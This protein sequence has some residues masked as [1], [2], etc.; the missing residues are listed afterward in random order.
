MLTNQWQSEPGHTNSALTAD[1]GGTALDAD[2]PAT[3]EFTKEVL[4]QLAAMT[5][6]PYIHIG[7]DET[8]EVSEVDYKKMIAAFSRQVTDLDKKVIGWSEYGTAG[9][10]PNSVIQA[11]TFKTQ[12]E[13]NSIIKNNAKVILSP[14]A[15]TYI[16]Q[17]Q[18]SAQEVGPAWACGGP[19]TLE[20]HYDWDPATHL[21]GIG[22]ARILG[23]ETVHWGE[24]MRT[25]DQ[26]ENFQYPRTLATAEVGWSPQAKRDYANFTQRA[27][28]FGGRM[29][30]EGI[31]YFK[32]SGVDW[33]T[34]PAAPETAPAL[35]DPAALP[36][37][38]PVDLGVPSTEFDGGEYLILKNLPVNAWLRTA[39]QNTSATEPT[40]PKSQWVLSNA[41]GE[42]PL[43]VP[44]G[45]EGGNYVVT[46]QNAAGQLAGFAALALAD[47]PGHGR[48]YQCHTHAR[49]AVARGQFTLHYSLRYSLR[50]EQFR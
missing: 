15:K 49:D 45:L 31:N 25:M 10:P 44:T 35:V 46:V 38:S 1:G 43:E 9:L 40:A 8:P 17:K 50:R 32:T 41:A 30:L 2:N 20:D 36:E 39:I 11:W 14:D 37:V 47:Q 22:D 23:M 6:G 13:A 27:G 7:G 18:D 24:F 33:S 28:T 19:C 4:T 5:P 3:Y 42:A 48:H 29:D 16:P 21:P 34:A 12:E 26:T